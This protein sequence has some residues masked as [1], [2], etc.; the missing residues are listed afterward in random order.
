MGP[1]KNKQKGG[2]LKIMEGGR[3]GRKIERG[4]RGGHG[5]GPYGVR[6]VGED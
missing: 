4:R 3:K 6:L 5:A 2:K 1:K